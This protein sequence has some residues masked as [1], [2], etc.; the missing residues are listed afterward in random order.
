MK[1]I[2][3]S[4]TN[5][6]NDQAKA[7]NPSTLIQHPSGHDVSSINNRQGGA[8]SSQSQ[9]QMAS[10]AGYDNKTPGQSNMLKS[11]SHVGTG[12]KI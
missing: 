8:Q 9:N 3:P 10:V 11:T 1:A 4:K 12:S 5:P 6:C 7:E 2:L